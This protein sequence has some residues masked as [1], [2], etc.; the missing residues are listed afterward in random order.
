MVM[1]YHGGIAGFSTAGYFGVDVF[2][3]LSGFLIT[4]LL[5]AEE[6]AKGRI[7]FGAFW[8]R[9]A[10][11]LLPGLLVMLV[12]VDVYVAR[13]APPGRYPGF[14]D[15]ALSVLSYVSNWH[16][17]AASSNYFAATGAPSLLTHTWSLAIEE[18]FYLVW[19]L[20]LWGLV[21][22][23]RRSG[24]SP[25][26]VVGTV[27]GLGALASATAM[28][29]MFRSGFGPS[30][31]YYGTDTHGQSILIGAA[32]A[33]WATTRPAV[34]ARIGWPPISVAAL[35]GLVAAACTLGSTDRVTYQGGFLVVGLLSA[36]VI[37]NLAGRPEEPLARALSARPV[38]YLG[39]ISYGMY[40]WYFPLFAVIDRAGTGLTGVALFAVRTAADIAIAAASF[41]VVEQPLRTWRPTARPI[42]APLATAC[43]SLGGVAALVLADSPAALSVTSPQPVAVSAPV[44]P[45]TTLR[46]LVIGDS[47]GLTL[48]DD[49]AW[50][51]V[52]ERYHYYVDVHATL[53]CG[54]AISSF[55][56]EHGQAKPV[57]PSCGTRTP[58]DRQ[59][60]ALLAADIARSHPDV[61]L[62]AA[63]RFEVTNRRS[64]P[65]GSWVDISQPADAAY[66]RRQLILADQIATAGRSRLAITTAPCFSSGETPDGGTWP[67]DQPSRV[68]TYNGIVRSV[69]AADPG[70]V[71]VVDVASAV[72][73]GGQ[74][75]TTIGGVTVRA[76]DGVHYPFFSVTAP[77]SPAPNSVA[78]AEAFGAWISPQLLGQITG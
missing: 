3:V 58:P 31:L 5:L 35:A 48:G 17:V 57:A 10:R 13:F 28:A 16:F 47:T 39:R 72:C 4:T 56:M 29:L 61:V 41:H 45:G 44:P 63:G 23:A 67:E 66:I 64:T 32:L 7:R 18:Q 74:F 54:V 19:P 11:R 21:R 27:A 51:E 50:P 6:S 55:E 70:H 73:P 8:A 71:R 49:M 76:P 22:L 69:A 68:A 78:Q 60:P 36:L 34:V 52:E 65:D 25:G 46:I 9:R 40:L 43:L 24:R 15:D 37:A 62:L 30:R 33:G 42:S 14:R 26:A 2:F 1:A 20:I 53:G 59:W 38:R 77:N 75:R 12:A